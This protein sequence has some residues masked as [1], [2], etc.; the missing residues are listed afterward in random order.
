[1]FLDISYDPARKAMLESFVTS[2]FP[3]W[4]HTPLLSLPSHKLPRALLEELLD[5]F[6]IDMQFPAYKPGT[7]GHASKK[8][9]WPIQAEEDLVKY[10][11]C[12]AGTVGEMFLH[13]VFSHSAPSTRELSYF[14]SRGGKM[15]IA[16]QYV[17]IARDIH[18]DAA[19]GR[20]YIPSAWLKEAGLTEEAVLADPACAVAFRDVLLKKAG[21]MYA[22][23]RGAIELL[24][25][26]ARGGAR[27]AIEGYMDI[28]R[29]ME[30][31]CAGDKS[32][33]DSRAARVIRMWKVMRG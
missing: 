31:G 4:A 3:A 27:V 26:E 17:N 7:K 33:R 30:G 28:G 23:S 24:P 25:E 19:M 11:Y 32:W 22:R 18:K 13:L 21:E 12:V 5:G 1:M 2:M 8:T 29:R 16:L 10:S 14:L 6:Q 20:V 15:G 9:A